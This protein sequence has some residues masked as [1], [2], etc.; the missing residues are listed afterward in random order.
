MN[1]ELLSQFARDFVILDVSVDSLLRMIEFPGDVSRGLA[2]EE[3]A[4]DFGLVGH[5][6]ANV[7]DSAPDGDGDLLFLLVLTQELSGAIFAQAT[8][9]AEIETGENA[10]LLVGIETPASEALLVEGALSRDGCQADA[11]HGARRPRHR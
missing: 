2:A 1:G 9:E 5:R 11:D 8:E 3:T 4:H 10:S 6:T 7:M